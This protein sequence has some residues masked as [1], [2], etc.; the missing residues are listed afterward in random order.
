ML[1]F[2]HGRRPNYLAERQ[3]QHRLAFV[4]I[5]KNNA[6]RLT[7]Y[8]SSAPC[9]LDDRRRRRRKRCEKSR[10]IKASSQ[11]RP[12]QEASAA[13]PSTL[14]PRVTMA[15]IIT[16]SPSLSIHPAW[17]FVTYN[18]MNEQFRR[19][20][21]GRGELPRCWCGSRMGGIGG[22]GNDSPAVSSHLH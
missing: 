3:P 16:L 7:E 2:H 4:R 11:H 1:L 5:T 10:G 13:S 20:E 9:R 12:T 18:A 19:S 14:S 6:C 21:G 15:L 22:D 17:I 8:F